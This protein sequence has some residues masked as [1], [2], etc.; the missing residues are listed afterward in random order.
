MDRRRRLCR[1][2]SRG[3][4]IK[5]FGRLPISLLVGAYGIRATPMVAADDDKGSLI[6]C[7]GR[8]RKTIVGLV[9]DLQTRRLK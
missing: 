9:G 3:R 4:F 8:K 1:G 2:P 5:L 6:A 7:S